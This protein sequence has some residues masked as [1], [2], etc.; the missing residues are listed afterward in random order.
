MQIKFQRPQKTSSNSHYTSKN[1]IIEVFNQQ[2]SYFQQPLCRSDQS[3]T[4]T[5]LRVPRLKSRNK[6]TTKVTIYN[7]NKMQLKSMLKGALVLTHQYIIL[8]YKH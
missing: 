6:Q 5:A 7:Q 1:T 3:N 4:F 8:C 2:S